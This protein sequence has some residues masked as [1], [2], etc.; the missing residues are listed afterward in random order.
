MFLTVYHYHFFV[1]MNSI[2]VY[3][4]SE[5]FAQYFPINWKVPHTHTAQLAMD[6]WGVTIWVL[7]AFALYYKEIF[8][9][10]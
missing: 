3:L 8:I 2:V 4:C 5:I 10:I 9:A 7:M 1:G 6:I